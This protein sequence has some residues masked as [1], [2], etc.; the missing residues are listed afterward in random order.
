[1]VG[2][3]GRKEEG[4]RREG[5]GKKGQCSKPTVR[6][7]SYFILFAAQIIA[8]LSP[9]QTINTFILIQNNSQWLLTIV[10]I[11]TGKMKS[12]TYFQFFVFRITSRA[13]N[14]NSNNDNNNDNNR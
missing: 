8:L 4:E 13:D 3:E 12:N 11:V 14:D 1:M 7:S 9:M 6:I 5:R 2:S 10:L